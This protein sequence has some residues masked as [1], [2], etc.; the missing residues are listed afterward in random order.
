MG[1][2]I[3]TGEVVSREVRLG[4]EFRLD[5]GK[6]LNELGLD[7]DCHDLTCDGRDEESSDPRCLLG[8]LSKH[9]VNILISSCIV[10]MKGDETYMLSMRG[11]MAVPSAQWIQ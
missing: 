10:W 7:V 5:V 3:R 4:R 11:Y 9:A 1:R 8:H 6:V 2:T